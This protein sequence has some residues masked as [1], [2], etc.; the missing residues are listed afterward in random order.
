VLRIWLQPLQ[1][2]VFS[3]KADSS[4]IVLDPRDNITDSSIATVDFIGQ[5][6]SFRAPG[7]WMWPAA[8]HG[9]A[10]CA[11]VFF[12]VNGLHKFSDKILVF[13]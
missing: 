6:R 1:S 11:N 5:G 10:G 4:A 3:V 7:P 2:R 8:D 13:M 12:I 9:R